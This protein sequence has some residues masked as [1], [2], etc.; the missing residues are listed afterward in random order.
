MSMALYIGCAAQE[1]CP[2]TPAEPTS[3]PFLLAPL[4]PAPPEAAPRPPALVSFKE[5]KTRTAL[6]DFVT[7]V[8]DESSPDFVPVESRI[9][10][11]DND[12]TLWSEQPLYFEF[13]F[14]LDR[15]L[16][17]LAQN[18]APAWSKKAW[19]VKLKKN[20][21]Q[22]MA[23]LDSKALLEIFVAANAG[24]DEAG[25]RV[26]ASEWFKKA[27]HPRFNR[28][29]SEL[30]FVPMVELLAYL[31]EHGFKTFIVSG[32]S[33][34]FIRVFAEVAYGILPEQVVGSYLDAKY[35]LRDGHG[36]VVAEPKLGF[37]DDGAGKPVGIARGIGRA[38]I[39]AVGNSDGDREML[40]Y[41]TSQAGARLG[42]LVHHDDAER[43]FA[44]DRGS[45]IGT[46]DKA[47]DQ[48]A[49]ARWLVVSMKNDFAIVYTPP[50]AA[51]VPPV[52][53]TGP[54]V[55]V[56]SATPGTPSLAP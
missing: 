45:K 20:G 52:E 11:F 5:G 7:R 4:P 55:P 9:A 48:A 8:T 21:K 34:R 44:Y 17:Q 13:E 3:E 37:I 24:L 43:E 27:K 29:Y 30:T 16:D 35:E 12:G 25:F 40:E 26:V 22:A 31:R 56:A 1:P 38:P 46:L 10:V 54:T 36:F 33:S 53:P 28:P 6:V 18:P 23:A 49:T 51:V 50:T 41:V 2:V 47:L 42:V 15:V 39:I 14:A 19:A 32:G